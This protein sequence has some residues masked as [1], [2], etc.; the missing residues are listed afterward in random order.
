MNW[1][2]NN[3]LE[4]YQTNR[5]I[6][7]SLTRNSCITLPARS[8]AGQRNERVVR[9]TRERWRRRSMRHP[10][11]L[12]LRDRSRISGLLR[13]ICASPRCEH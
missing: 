2:E 7:D 1:S 4:R 12:D 5:L 10:L 8:S 6:I 11:L 3:Q 9:S 13:V